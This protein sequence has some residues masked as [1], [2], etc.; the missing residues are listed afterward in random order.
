MADVDADLLDDVVELSEFLSESAQYLA[1]IPATTVHFTP[2][3]FFQNDPDIVFVTLADA[4][5]FGSDSFV[6]GLSYGITIADALEF[7]DAWERL[8][9]AMVTLADTLAFA[10]LFELTGSF[11]AE[12]FDAF[13]LADYTNPERPYAAGWVLNLDTN[14]PSRYNWPL[15]NSFATLDGIAYGASEDGI[16]QLEGSDDF[17]DNVRWFLMT[18]KEIFES[19][20]AKNVSRGYLIAKFDG[21]VY[22]KTVVAGTDSTRTYRLVST[23]DELLQRRLPLGKGPRAVRWQFALQDANDGG[24]IEA[25]AIAVYPVVLTRRFP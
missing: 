16:F 17:G 23:N 15:Y 3:Y 5:T 25:D 9:W 6:P 11:G 12:F 13:V 19:P 20:M 8:R 22:F 14:A 1:D 4:A 24:D 18:G 2:D 7:S 10:E 21:S